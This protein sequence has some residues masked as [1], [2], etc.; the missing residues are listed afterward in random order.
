LFHRRVITHLK[1]QN[2]TGVGLDLAI[3][4]VGVF[5]GTQVSNWNQERIQKHEAERMLIEI[6]PALRHFTDFFDTAKPYYATTGAY[7]DTALAGWR[8]DPAVGDKQFVIAAY[9]A[10]QIYTLGISGENWTAI[11]GGDRLRDIDDEELRRRLAA[12]M[13]IDYDAVEQISVDTPYRQHVRQVIPEEI[14]DAIRAKC[15]DKPIGKSLEVIELPSSC[16]I[17]LPDSAFAA[18]AA[19]LRTKPE[20]VGELRWHRSEVA[21]FLANL[22]AIESQTRQLQEAIDKAVKP[23]S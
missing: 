8:G 19:A 2:W 13:T 1:A 10:S 15:S 16:D 5:I 11:F 9:Q 22:G 14:Q 17:D 23:G 4:I 20:L 6:R 21:A 18:G 12:L 3:V 7:S